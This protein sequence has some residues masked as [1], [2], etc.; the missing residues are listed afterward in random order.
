VDSIYKVPLMLH[1]QGLDQVIVDSLNIWTGAPNLTEWQRICSILDN[2]EQSC[3][4]GIVGKY[5]GV[6]DSY[7]SITEALTHAGISNRCK[8]E[9]EFIDAEQ[10]SGENQERILGSVDG[11][12][13]PGGFGNRGIEGKIAAIRYL[14]ESNKPFFGICLG[15]QLAAIEFARHRLGISGATSQEFEH[16]ASD[17]IVHLME[18]QKQVAAKGGTMRLGAYP[19]AIRSGTRAF[20]AYGKAQISERHRHRLE[21]NNQ[22][23]P[24]FEK[25]GVIFSGLSPD[26]SLVEIMEIADHPWFIGV[27][28]HPEL[29][30]SP[31]NCHPLFRDFIASA[32][33]VKRDRSS[34]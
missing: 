19:C 4:I 23:R 29:K 21:F 18:S 16:S 26:E 28:F 5:V 6:I 9:L 3:R 31:M 17:P 30:S 27:Q 2:P 32:L 33:R 14:R 12:I 8:V 13:V 25:A 34:S 24:A 10:I 11:V 15:M 1:R 22:Y 7:K 20:S